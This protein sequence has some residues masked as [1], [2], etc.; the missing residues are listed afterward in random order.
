MRVDWISGCGAPV[1]VHMLTSDQAHF[2]AART[3]DHLTGWV[4]RVSFA[5]PGLFQLDAAIVDTRNLTTKSFLFPESVR[6]DTGVPP[7]DLSPDEQ[8]F[9]WLVQ[10]ADEEPRLGVTNWRTGESYVLPINRARMRF[11]TASSLDPRWVRHHFQWTRGPSGTDIL[12]ERPD[13]VV[14]PYRGDLTLGKPGEAQGYTLRPGG[15]ALRAAVVDLLVRDVGGE[16]LP[17]EPDGFQQ[18]VRVNGRTLNVS[19]FGSYVAVAMDAPEGD[20]QSMSAIAAKLDAALA[21][22]KYDALFVAANERK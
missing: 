1:T 12:T 16:R 19:V 11:N 4:D 18:R 22:G 20:P 5:R 6:P 14:L 15:D 10:G 9:A 3:H 13:F 17:D 2:T 21:S 8:S 7:V